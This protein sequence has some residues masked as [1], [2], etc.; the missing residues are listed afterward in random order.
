MKTPPEVAEL[1]ILVVDD[2]EMSVVLLE[3]LLE[4]WGYANI[5]TTSESSE[6]EALVQLHEPDLVIL[7]LWMP[8]P[9]GFETLELLQQ[10]RSR[11]FVPVLIM[12]SDVSR[13]AR[14]R[15]LVLGATDFVEKPFDPDQLRLR[16]ANLLEIRRLH[17]GRTLEAEHARLEV[18]ERLGHAAEFRDDSTQDHP[19]RVGRTAA[20]LGSL[21][22]MTMDEVDLVRRA[23]PLHDVGKIGISDAILLKPGPLRPDELEAMK[24]HTLIGSAILAD[25]SSE[26]LQAAEEI[27]R[28]HHERW[29]GTGYP[30]GLAG[31]E[32]P[33]AGRVTAVA[34]VFDALTHDRPYRR[35]CPIDDAAAE[36]RALAG[37]HL[38]P[39][40]VEAFESLDRAPLLAPTPRVPQRRFQRKRAGP[41]GP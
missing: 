16:I 3:R 17:L 12:S 33:L 18:L 26:L 40:V 20:L 11:T 2:E 32:I 35:A 24:E 5:V 13:S 34:D 22:G 15:A 39:Q 23:A 27:A 31:D 7:D 9:D 4:R 1:R 8:S 10:Q 19:D 29:D 14:E 36:I 28:T 38:D 6:I 21:C 41:A 30:A 37:T 25:S